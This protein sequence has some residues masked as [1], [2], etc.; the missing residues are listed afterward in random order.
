MLYFS[1]APVVPDSLDQE[2][3]NKLKEFK[4]W[5]M[6]KGLVAEF[7]DAEEFR[8]K[9]RRDLELN[10]RDNDHLAAELA[11]RERGED[12]APDTRRVTLSTEAVRLLTAAASSDDGLIMILQTHG[13]PLVKAGHVNMVE[14]ETAREAA[15]WK[16][17]IEELEGFGLIEASSYKRE[18]FRLSHAGWEA[19]EQLL[20]SGAAAAQPA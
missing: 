13:G 14:N 8:E 11:P 18:V 15:R 4:S 2:Q 1:K 16:A 19:A 9:F 5:A 20:Q 10:L 6:S 17:A 3:Y 12:D 7:D